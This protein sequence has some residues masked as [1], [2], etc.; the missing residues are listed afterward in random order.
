MT[1]HFLRELLAAVDRNLPSPRR[2]RHGRHGRA[3]SD[4]RRSGGQQAG[5]G[6]SP[7]R[8]GARSGRRSRRHLG[9]ASRVWWAWPW[10]SSMRTCSARTRSSAAIPICTSRR[11]ICSPFLRET[12]TAAGS[13]HQRGGRPSLS[14][15]LAARQ[16][17]RADLQPDGR[18]RHGRN[19]AGPDLAMDPQP[20][21]RF[22]DGTKVTAELVA[23]GASQMNW[24]PCAPSLGERPT[25][26]PA[27]TPP[28]NCS[29]QISTRREFVDF[30]TLPAYEQ[31]P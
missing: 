15:K 6:Q 16:R 1:T 30:L 14:G 25:P 26:R 8:Q 12:I 10:K 23:A 3:D 5:S 28:A 27:S 9:R 20:G 13:A 29:C 17:L 4:Q 24:P 11:T 22:A 18:R 7:G 2:A 31:L 21:G 19:L